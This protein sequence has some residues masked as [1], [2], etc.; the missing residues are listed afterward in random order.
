MKG[1]EKIAAAFSKKALSPL[2]APRPFLACVIFPLHLQGP[3]LVSDGML[4]EALKGTMGEGSYS[5]LVISPARQYFYPQICVVYP[6]RQIEK[7]RALLSQRLFTAP[8]F[9]C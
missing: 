2:L 9:T 7:L 5:S 1:G 6:R 8:R 3:P 4:E